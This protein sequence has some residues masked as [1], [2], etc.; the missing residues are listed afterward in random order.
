MKSI[1]IICLTL[2]IGLAET[3][4]LTP[5]A[6]AKG[7]TVPKTRSLIPTPPKTRT[8]TGVSL[9]STRGP[10]VQKNNPD[11]ALISVESSTPG[12]IEDDEVSETSEICVYED[13]SIELPILFHKGMATI[14][15]QDTT[16]LNNITVLAET[17]QS[18]RALKVAIVGQTCDLGNESYNNT[19]SFRRALAVYQAL[20]QQYGISHSRLRV[21]GQGES[22]VEPSIC[23][24]PDTTEFEHIRRPLRKVTLLRISE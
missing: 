15:T 3:A 20:T 17:L 11:Y 19:L 4:S 5:S 14:D 1:L 13:I 21:Q 10:K 8:I 6:L 18:D 16:S 2:Q 22:Q 7:L 12:L 23:S 9:R 24:L